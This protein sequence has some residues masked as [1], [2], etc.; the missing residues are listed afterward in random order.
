MTAYETIRYDLTDGVAEIRLDRPDSLNSLD[1]RMRSELAH[2]FERAPADGARAVLMTGSGRSFCSGQDL[3]EAGAG[4][5]RDVD[6]TLRE[7][8]E[9]ML[10]AVLHCP[11]PVVVALNGVA[12]GAGASLAL[13]GDVVIAGSSAQIVIAFARIGLAPDVGA[14]WM[15]PRLVGLPRAMGM[16]LTTEPIDAKRA[17]EWGLVW[18]AVADEAL[19]T[20]ARG[21]AGAFA[22]GPT[23]A[24]A[25]TKKALRD[26]LAADLENHL[27]A[28]AT[29]QAEAASTRDFAEGTAAFMEKRQPAFEGR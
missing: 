13:L 19:M 11:M 1:K 20:E 22:K 18:K 6:R 24:F 21:L 7:Q 29:A 25:L 26:G 2:A 8:Y 16:A 17:A 9:P 4:G 3:G 23:K 14:T 12:A 28:E 10:R 27:R 5:I 15:L